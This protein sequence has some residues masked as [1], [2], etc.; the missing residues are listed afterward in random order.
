MSRSP[1][2]V[3][4]EDLSTVIDGEADEALLRRVHDDPE[5]V[6]RLASMRAAVDLLRTP[7][8]APDAATVDALV[9]RALREADEPA[10]SDHGSSAD[11]TPL[12]RR[13]APGTA[14]PR[15]LVA[16]VVVALAAIGLGLVW[17]GTRST[18]RVSTAGDS[19][20]GSAA[21][22]AS[23]LRGLGPLLDLGTH[24]SIDD[25]RSALSNGVRAAAVS[26]T[27]DA[28]DDA[29]TPSP[30]SVSRCAV[31]ILE[32]L[33]AE[34][35]AQPPTANGIATVDG[36]PMLVYE[37]DLTSGDHDAMISIAAPTDCSPRASFYL[38]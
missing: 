12:P 2:P 19:L 26:T 33:R 17:S 4:D 8:P 7:P 27:T 35:L 20:D 18:D 24:D 9:A 23:L 34:P 29:D 28:G 1:H 38:D 3:S 5:A 6:G 37:F 13:S 22:D 11:V 32:L 14:A 16:A 15:W 21:Q 25:L 30:A 10:P 31:Q 36:S